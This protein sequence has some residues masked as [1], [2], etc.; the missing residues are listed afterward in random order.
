MLEN[1]ADAAFRRGEL[2]RSQALAS[3]ALAI[4]RTTTDVKLLTLALVGA[5]QIASARGEHAVAAEL[6][7]ESLTRTNQAGYWIGWAD[8]LGGCASVAVAAGQTATAAQLLSAA[9]AVCEEIGMPRLLHQAQYQRTLAAVQMRLDEEQFAAAWS[10]GGEL[11]HEEVRIAAEDVLRAGTLADAGV[12][13]SPAERFGL[14]PRERQVLRLL[15][16]GQSD[17]EIGEALFISHRTVMA[18]VAHILAKLDVPSRAA[19]AQVSLREGL[20]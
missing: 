11:T 13:A 4:G 8:T 2:S 17:K 7:V 15:V 16:E 3:E 19:A 14:T 10:A 18:H 12:S 1:L 9:M 20:L 5:A 6:L